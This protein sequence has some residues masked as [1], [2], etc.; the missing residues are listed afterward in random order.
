[1]NEADAYKN[2]IV[3]RAKGEAEKRIAAAK[4]YKEQVIK[5]AEGEAARFISVYDT[6]KV[7]KDVTTQRLFLE[8]MQEV[9]GRANKIIIDKNAG[10]ESG[11]VPYLPLN[12]LQKRSGGTQ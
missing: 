12:E 8:R 1:V 6:Y 10:G 9:L 4:A 5:E 11:V 2:D 3:P 7:A